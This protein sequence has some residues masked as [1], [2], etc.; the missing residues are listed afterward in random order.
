MYNQKS[1][2]VFE[3]GRIARIGKYAVTVV[4]ED[5][6]EILIS[7]GAL[8]LTLGSGT[9]LLMESDVMFRTDEIDAL[10]MEMEAELLS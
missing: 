7:S 10:V 4:D 8:F 6:R 9:F 2:W 5:H 1:D 3:P